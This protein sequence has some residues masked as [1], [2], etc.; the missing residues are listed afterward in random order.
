MVTVIWCTRT[1][2]WRVRLVLTEHQARLVAYFD[3]ISEQLVA[4]LL[5]AEELVEQRN[6]GLLMLTPV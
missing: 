6:A 5:A 4:D 3:D 1:N 2:R